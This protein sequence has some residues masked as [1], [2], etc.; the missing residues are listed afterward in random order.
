MPKGL[1]FSGQ[2]LFTDARRRVFFLIYEDL[3]TFGIE[4][5][6]LV[7][8]AL[9]DQK[10]QRVEDC[11]GFLV[12][13]SNTN[14]VLLSETDFFIQSQN[15]KG[16]RIFSV[17]DQKYYVSTGTSN[18]GSLNTFPSVAFPF[19]GMDYRGWFVKCCA[20]PDAF[21]LIELSERFYC[22][23]VSNFLQR[24]SSYEQ[25]R[26]SALV[27]D[28]YNFWDEKRKMHRFVCSHVWENG[29]FLKS[30]VPSM[31]RPTYFMSIKF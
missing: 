5:F 16:R 21:W 19:F 15:L 10:L 6:P 29:R 12:D 31:K 30:T 2:H 20:P 26:T 14:I 25:L 28:M 4:C 13:A 24:F 1:V 11:S 9:K 22:P 17:D 27:K 3:E 8:V 23:K 7:F 18:N